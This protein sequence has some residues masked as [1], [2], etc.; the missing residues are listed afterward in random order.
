[1]KMSS[2]GARRLRRPSVESLEMRTMLDA[3]HLPLGINLTGNFSDSTQA[4]FVD[5]FKQAEAWQPL[6]GVDAP[7]TADG[8]PTAPAKTYTQMSAYPDG[9]YKLSYQGTGT[10]DFSGVSTLIAATKAQDATGTHYAD[11]Q[12]THADDGNLRL[13]ITS[14]SPTDPIHNMHLYAPGYATDGSQTFTDVFLKRLQPFN[15]IRTMDWTG[16]NNSTQV[17]WS[18]RV[19]PTSFLQA[20]QRGVAWETIIALANQT[21]KDLW[22]NVPDAATN[23]YVTQ[24]ADL[25]RN[26]LHADAHIYVELS[27]EL[28]SGGNQQYYRT[29]ATA[30]LNEKTAANP[31]G[32]LPTTNG[33]DWALEGEQQAYRLKQVGDIFRQEY[34][35]AAAGNLAGQVRPILGGFL[36][37]HEHLG[38]AL[39]FLQD[40][41]GT[42]GN[43]IYGLGEATYASMNSDDDVP[44]LTMDG[45][46][47][48]I[49]NHIATVE[50]T[51]ITQAKAQADAYGLHLLGY[52][53]G[54]TLGYNDSDPNAALLAAAQ[55]DPRMGQV[56]VDEYNT[57]QRLGGEEVEHFAFAGMYN[58]SDGFG[59]LRSQAEPGEAKWDAIAKYL[60]PGG[61]ST[62]DGK[63]DGSDLAVL[64]ANYRAAGTRWWEQGDA[65]LDNKVDASDLNLL[66]TN[67]GPV[68]AEVAAQA[69]T[70]APG[71]TGVVGKPIT[72]DAAGHVGTA[73]FIWI[74]PR[75]SV[76]AGFGSGAKFTF[77]PKVAGTYQV[78]LLTRD[79]AGNRAS[80]SVSIA[81]G[82]VADP[83]TVDDAS[84]DAWTAGPG[85]VAGTAGYAAGSRKLA[86]GNTASTATWLATSP[87][88]TAGTYQVQSTWTPNALQSAKAT[89]RIYDGDTLVGTVAINQRFAPVGN[90]HNGATFQSLGNFR[91]GTGTLRVV[92]VGSTDGAVVADAVRVVAPPAARFAAFNNGGSSA[93]LVLPPN[94]FPPSVPLITKGKATPKTPALA[95]PLA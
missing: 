69:A 27:N 76:S 40:T 68:N 62:L 85:W 52:E 51:Q 31:N 35:H 16:T 10:L 74:A 3:S 32:V 78:V 12:V 56:L 24:L 90:A 89:Y 94:V 46:F 80:A 91:S 49:H 59:L 14:T 79:A 53:G 1:M 72:L 70:F 64:T 38:P 73:S 37:Y 33:Y 87:S 6:S 28:W 22:I 9:T 63:V 7:M 30:K 2:R 88:A 60:L 8:Y 44:G 29:L 36:S 5:V 20:G 48:S 95:V 66:R 34:A 13:S 11:V 83:G 57:W 93:S 81:V 43:Y 58:S 47:A 75:G 84:A 65:N 4:A 17:D 19:L 77:T 92:L 26:N 21:H 50:T 45:L 71:V 23:A 55:F 41:Y 82:A 39:Q 25:M 18:D 54:Q 61:D 67:L 86:A 42:P 15:T